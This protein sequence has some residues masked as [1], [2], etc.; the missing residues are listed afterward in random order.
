MSATYELIDNNIREWIEK[1]HMFFVGTAP[2]SKSGSINISPKG[3]D[4]LRVVNEKTLAY[5]DLGGSGIETISHIRENSRV[6][7]MMCAFEGPPKIYRFHGNGEILL[8]NDA[9]FDDLSS[10][11]DRANLGIRAIII[12]HVERISD[13]CGFGVP[14]Y[15]YQGDR[16]TLPNYIKKYGV[17][18][19]RKFLQEKNEKSIDG[20]P[21]FSREE[22]HLYRG[23]MP[24]DD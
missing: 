24:E 8:P 1:Q 10:S 12:V 13:S 21:G 20:L 22:A 9:R 2:L 19:F 15:N 18:S 11:F 14:L 5:M 17:A 4:T 7:I 16:P 6:V 23:A 3:L